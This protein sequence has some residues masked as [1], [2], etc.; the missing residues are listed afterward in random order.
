MIIFGSIAKGEERPDSDIDLFVLVK[1]KKH[2]KEAWLTTD[3]LNESLI[4]VL[5]N[6]ISAI[7]YSSKEL[8]GKKEL[9]L[10]R[11]IN[12]ESEIVVSHG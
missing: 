7:I 12:E 1:E 10:V 5:G 6:M 2:K 9:D 4:P 3:K 11:H 8:K